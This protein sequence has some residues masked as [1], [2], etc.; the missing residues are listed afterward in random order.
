VQDKAE[1]EERAQKLRKVEEEIKQL[2]GLIES[3]KTRGLRFLVIWDSWT[4]EEKK[5]FAEGV[6]YPHI[7]HIRMRVRVRVR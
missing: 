5:I 3:A 7:T 1:W 6:G 4:D 2:H